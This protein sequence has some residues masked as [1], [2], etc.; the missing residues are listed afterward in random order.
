MHSEFMVPINKSKL[1][2][3]KKTRFFIMCS[4]L[5]TCQE[6]AFY[7]YTYLWYQFVCACVDVY[8]YTYAH[9]CVNAK[10]SMEFN[11]FY[12]VNTMLYN[13]CLQFDFVSCSTYWPPVLSTHTSFPIQ[14]CN[15]YFNNDLFIDRIKCM[16]KV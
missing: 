7:F 8:I 9:T 12:T 13:C 2:F 10:A 1:M 4:V 14:H 16:H 15:K 6:I 3:S 11:L 5:A